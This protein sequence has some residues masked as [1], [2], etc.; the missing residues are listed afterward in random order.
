MDPITPVKSS[1]DIAPCSPLK[2][3][4]RFGGTYHRARYQRESRWQTC[5]HSGILIGLFDPEDGGDTLF[6][7]CG[8]LTFKGLQG[9]ISQMIAF[10]VTA[11]VI[12]SNHT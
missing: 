9:V 8:R 12:I 2:V 4:R 11:A 5:L 7:K 1:W 10:F 3:N 6:R